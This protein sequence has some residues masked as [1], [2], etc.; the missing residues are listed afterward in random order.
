MKSCVSIALD[1]ICDAYVLYGVTKTNKAFKEY[2]DSNP[3]DME[4]GIKVRI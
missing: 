2:F 3:K 1:I 4:L